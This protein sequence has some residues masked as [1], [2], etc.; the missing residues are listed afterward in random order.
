[1]YVEKEKGAKAMAK[2]TG[3]AVDIVMPLT[4]DGFALV[5][6]KDGRGYLAEVKEAML[7]EELSRRAQTCT[8]RL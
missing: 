7:Y 2:N 6:L 3:L 1:M 5:A 8:L 4:A